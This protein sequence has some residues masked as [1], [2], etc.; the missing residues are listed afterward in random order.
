M[1]CQ[2]SVSLCNA[3][4]IKIHQINSEL[5]IEQI[6]ALGYLWA[7]AIKPGK[8][9]G[10]NMETMETEKERIHRGLD[11]LMALAE[12]IRDAGTA[13]K[14]P[15]YAALMSR[16]SLEGFERAL[17]ILERAGVIRQTIETVTWTGPAKGGA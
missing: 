13:P 11:V 1:S 10:N 6:L 4:L 7:R 14:G 15:M 16:L 3:I 17:G 12:V 5:K 8:K 9:I 2:S